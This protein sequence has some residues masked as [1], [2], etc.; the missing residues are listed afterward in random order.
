MNNKVYFEY[1]KNCHTVFYDHQMIEC[2]TCGV[3]GEFGVVV[4][5]T[6]KETAS[7]CLSCDGSGLQLGS[8]NKCHSCNGMGHV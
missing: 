7:N 8:R 4:F 3:W 5:N 2:P 6:E 1:C